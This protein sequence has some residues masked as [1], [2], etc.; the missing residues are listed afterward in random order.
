MLITH[1]SD[2]HLF[3][4]TPES[5]LVRPDI[6]DVLRRI[7]ADVSAFRPAVD[8][9]VL[10]GDLTEVARTRI[11]PCCGRFF[12]HF[13]QWS[14]PYRAIMTYEPTFAERSTIS[15]PSTTVSSCTLRDGP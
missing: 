14:S 7:V 9:V 10:T 1:L 6:V 2:F 15:C 12:R 3:T 4:K 13:R 11:T 8:A 5:S